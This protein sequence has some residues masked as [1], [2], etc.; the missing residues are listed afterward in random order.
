VSEP[1][2]CKHCGERIQK[3]YRGVWH[4]LSGAITKYLCLWHS[5]SSRHAPA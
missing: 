1:V 5:N 2:K 4:D 3:D